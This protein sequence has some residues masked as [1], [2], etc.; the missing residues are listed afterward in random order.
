MRRFA[1]G[2]APPDQHAAFA[3][4]HQSEDRAQQRRFA[5]AVASHQADR[6]GARDAQPDAVQD[7]ARAVVAV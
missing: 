2:V 3:R 5:H 1:R 6:L 4:G 7:V